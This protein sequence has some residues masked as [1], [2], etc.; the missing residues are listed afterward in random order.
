MSSLFQATMQLFRDGINTFRT[1]S[2]WRQLTLFIAITLAVFTTLVVDVPDLQTLQQW[3]LAT[4]AWFPALFVSLYIGITQFPIPRT[5]MTLSAG[6]LFG[7]KLGIVLA[8]L[9]T[10]LSAGLSMLL[11]RQL[12]GGSVR[13]QSSHPLFHGIQVR[14]QE[15]GWLAITSLRMIAAVPFSLLNYAAAL[16]PISLLGFCVATFIGSAPGTIVTVALG[17]S[18]AH[19]FSAQSVLPVLGIAT[20]GCLGLLLDATLP[21]QSETE[22]VKSEI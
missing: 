21:L 11:I 8:L 19:E 6:V 9:A 4:G 2:R 16:S 18:F 13:P 17:N 7:P 22:I 14:L 1:W 3:A 12:F 10:T 20:L 5:V 15:R